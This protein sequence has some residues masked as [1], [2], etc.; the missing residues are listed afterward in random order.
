MNKEMKEQ[1]VSRLSSKLEQATFAILTDY[2]GLTVEQITRLRNE[3]R[4]VSS[5]YQVVKNTL[6]KIASKGTEFEQL[7]QHFAGPTA[8]LL[9]SDDPITPSKILAKFL[10]EYSALSIKAGFLQGKVLSVEEAKELSSLPGRKELLAK[11]VSLCISP[12]VR[13]L[14]ALNFVPL[15]LVQVLNAIQKSKSGKQN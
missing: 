5:D 7:H 10:K 11:L 3:L 12:Q 14:N 6:F 2:R 9:S 15:K 13:L 8:I 1:I 4:G